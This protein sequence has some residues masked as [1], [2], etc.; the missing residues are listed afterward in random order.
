MNFLKYFPKNSEGM[1]IVYEIYSFENLFRL[2]LKE[3]Y[4]HEDA[5]MFV[6]TSCSLSALVF[7]EGIYNKSY[8]KLSAEDALSPQ[9][10]AIKSQF[11]WYIC[12]CRRRYC[13]KK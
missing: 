6:L 12:Q 4:D 9:E 5:L 8:L 3:G 2:L 13:R 7:Q 1:H 10:A 11:V